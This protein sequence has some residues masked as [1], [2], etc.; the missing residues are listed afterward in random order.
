MDLP[1]ACPQYH[2]HMPPRYATSC[3]QSLEILR[4]QR[5]QQYEQI[6]EHKFS[7]QT[8]ERNAREQWRQEFH[9]PWW[10]R[11]SSYRGHRNIQP[12]LG[13]RQQGNCRLVRP[14]R[15]ESAYG[16]DSSASGINVKKDWE[17]KTSASVSRP[18]LFGNV[19]KEWENDSSAGV[20][21]PLPH[22]L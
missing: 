18:S 1:R 16:R 21:L 6:L 20:P 2:Q 3:R 19:S 9:T 11:L 14:G 17:V 4:S 15:A 10:S 12:Y 7:R 13:S 22:G 8:T 5:K